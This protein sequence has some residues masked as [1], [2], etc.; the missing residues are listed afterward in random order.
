MTGPDEGYVLGV[1][2]GTSHTVGM[3]RRPDG[4]V[5][6]LLFD[7]QPLLPSAV[8]VDAE[9]RLHVGRDAV[10]LGHAEPARFEPN[11]KRHIDA[12]TVLLGGAEMAVS[13]LF[14]GLLG[15]VAREAV[16][17][18][19][20]LPPAVVTYPANW[21]LHRRAVLTDALGR[22]GWPAGTEL[23]PEPVAAA[24]YFTDVL[25]RPVPAGS[26]LAV[27]DFGG[28]TLDIAVV[29][30]VG[31]GRPEFEVAASGGANDLGGLDLDS[32]L[33]DHLGKQLAGAEPEAWKALTDP[34]TLAQWRARRQFW[35]DVRGAKEMLSRS[36]VAPVPVPGVEHAMHLT[37]DELEAAAGPLIRRGVAEAAS[38]IKA[39]GLAPRDL[40]GLFLVGGSSR[41]PMVARLLHSELGI[42]PT[43]LDQPELPVSEG[44]ILAGGTS[45]TR[46]ASAAPGHQAGPDHQAAPSGFAAAAAGG[47][48]AA[49]AGAAA[50]ARAVPGGRVD[51]TQAAPPD[52]TQPGGR[53]DAAPTGGRS[54]ATQAA[55]PD[56]TEPGAPPSAAGAGPGPHSA[57]PHGADSSA[58]AGPNGAHGAGAHGAGAHGAGAHGGAAHGAAA[59]AA[60]H[61]PAQPDLGPPW[62]A[63]YAEAVDPWAT[64]EAAAL[65]ASGGAPLFPASG[66]PV[67]ST[68]APKP[69]D[70]P[71]L[72]SQ[73][74]DHPPTPS[75]MAPDRHDPSGDVPAQPWP[76]AATG[77]GAAR[78][79]YRRKWIWIVAAATVVVVGAGAVGAWVFWPG[80]RA[81]DFQQFGDPVV[82]TP[83]TPVSTNFSDTAVTGGRAYFASEANEGQLDVIAA[84]AAT[85]KQVWTSKSAGLAESWDR[86]VAVPAGLA[87]LTDVEGGSDQRRF[88]ILGADKGE[89]LWERAIA[90][91]D[92][93][94][95]EGDTAVLVDRTESRLLGLD[96]K[97]GRVKWEKPNLRNSSGTA[98]ASVY[99]VTTPAELSGPAGI[100]GVPFDEDPDSDHRIVQ[101]GADKSVRVLDAGSGEILASR[102]GVADYD[103]PMVAHN[104]RL[105]VRESSTP[106]TLVAYDLAKLG[107]G[108]KRVLYTAPENTQ[109]DKLTPCGDDGVC[110]VEEDGYKADSAKVGWVNAADGSGSRQ[111]AV[112]NTEGLVPVGDSVLA[113]RSTSPA[114]SVSLLD[115]S[116]KITWTRDGMA[117]R[118]DAGNVLT[119]TKS[120]STSPVDPA[121]AGQHLGDNFVQLGSMSDV[122]TAS[123]SWN[124]SV[125]A[126]VRSEDYVIQRFAK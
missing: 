115:D 5:R 80:Y 79:P 85:G 17:A 125:I 117:A 21:G 77:P 24:R 33:V 107:E 49:G 106:Q 72:A 1:D 7:G 20:F 43:V 59:G 81:L 126:C 27:F 51:A 25:R 97:T 101:A 88:M 63:D 96:I 118:L 76:P 104:G 36:A 122:R 112:P 75:W 124:T 41:V 65:A 86:M 6:P 9:R 38:V 40:A 8:Y 60:S 52:F 68:A 23:V 87:L 66:A 3:L 71:W 32:A 56:F 114:E 83:T 98:T 34:V 47:G 92:V 62:D 64:G 10:R 18:V 19:G 53:S 119:F 42:A 70:E 103:D 123:C 110:W 105:V 39:A 13:E 111:T 108:Q 30:N 121:L 45:A 15:A 95:F 46:P 22:A 84:D 31:A 28:G 89:K 11:P 120:L 102:A 50:A 54:E 82:I 61:V 78:R 44:A 14:A 57:A 73:H 94:F 99:S 90:R 35:E 2:L 48:A 93:F 58:A 91:D 100:A 37:R 67:T 109:I 16:A 4:R 69:A 113:L 74:G 55:P 26:A 29:R 116:G 12:G